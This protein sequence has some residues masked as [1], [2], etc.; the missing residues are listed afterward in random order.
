MTLSYPSKIS[1]NFF[2]LF[3][4][5]LTNQTII[6]MQVLS[7][8]LNTSLLPNT[9]TI[10]QDH[11]PSIHT[12]MCF[13]DKNLP[14]SKEVRKT[15]IGHLFEHML[16]E[17][18]YQI[19]ISR[20]YTNVSV[21]G[22]TQWDWYKTPMGFFTIYLNLGSDEQY[23]FFTAL[24]PAIQLLQFIFQDHQKN[25]VGVKSIPSSEKNFTPVLVS[26]S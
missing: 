16:L 9:Y 23:I 5:P 2:S 1:T 17:Y 3:I 25:H 18:I 26:K 13:N 7:P 21:K 22:E 4:R 19:K 14:F 6:D 8:I 10:L 20:G 15:E 11:L 24:T 12:S